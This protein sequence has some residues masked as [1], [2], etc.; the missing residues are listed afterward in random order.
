MAPKLSLSLPILTLL[1]LVLPLKSNAGGIA[2]YWGQGDGEGTLTE[3]CNSGLYKYVNIAFLFKFGN[4]QTPQLNLAGHCDPASGGCK[5]LSNDIRNCQNRGIKVLLSIGGGAGSYTLTSQNDARAVARYLWDNFLGGHSNN[6]PLGDAVLDG[7]DFDIEQGG[8]QYYPDLAGRLYQLG[9][10]GGKKLYLS[11]APQCPFPDRWTN[12]A[13]KTGLF[14]FVWIQFYNNPECE[15]SPSNPNAFKSSW[16]KWTSSIPA[17]KFLVGLSASPSAAGNGFVGAN[18]MNSQV[19][20]FVKQSPK[21]GGV[22]LWDRGY[23]KRTGY[24]SHFIGNV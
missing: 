16:S 19:L 8:S 15:F 18:Y 14:D 20:P 23:D 2:V 6:R 13:L 4:G 17:K 1:L 24:S 7:I 22:M 12:A 10:G 3:T 5:S 11:A 9:L 21:Y